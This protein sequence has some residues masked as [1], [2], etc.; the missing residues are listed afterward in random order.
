MKT[1]TKGELVYLRNLYE[2][3]LKSESENNYTQTLDKIQSIIDEANAVDFFGDV[4]FSHR[5]RKQMPT[6]KFKKKRRYVLHLTQG[7]I[8]EICGSLN[9]LRDDLWDYDKPLWNKLTKLWEKVCN[10]RENGM[11]SV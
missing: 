5:T 4:L 3:D 1:L 11:K 10:V 6:Y 9:I 7:E 8:N 2:A